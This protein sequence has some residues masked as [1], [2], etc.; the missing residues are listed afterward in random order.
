MKLTLQQIADNTAYCE[1]EIILRYQKMTPEILRLIER[2]NQET[3]CIYEDTC[4]AGCDDI[5]RSRTDVGGEWLFS[6]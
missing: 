6:L 2:I 3:F 1:D 4:P 5:G